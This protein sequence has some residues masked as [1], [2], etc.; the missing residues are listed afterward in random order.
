MPT[1]AQRLIHA[2]RSGN[3]ERLRLLIREHNGVM[4]C[5]AAGRTALHAAAEEGDR[6]AARILIEAGAEVN[7]R[8]KTGATPLH[9]AVSRG[10][11]CDLSDADLDRRGPC[12]RSKQH[13]TNPEVAEAMM[14]IIKER[15]PE[16]PADLKLE[17]KIPERFKG[18]MFAAVWEC[19]ARPAELYAGIKA[20]GVDID[21]LDPEFS[22][23]L[24]GDPRY[25]GIVEFLLEH[26]AD[27]NAIDL[28]GGT[29]LRGAVELGQ[30][31]VVTFLLERGAKV[32][33]PLSPHGFA[34]S[35][36]EIALES[37]RTK[38]ADLLLQYGAKLDLTSPGA[39]HEAAS[40][41]R[42]QVLSWLLDHDADI[43]IRNDYGQTPL[44]A[45]AGHAEA[46]NLL[47]ERGAD[48]QARNDKGEGL[49]HLCAG[50]TPCLP[51]LLSRGL[52]V[53]EPNV[54]GNTPLH[55]AA[56]TGEPT[57]IQMLIKAGADV[58]Q[59]NHAGN[60]SLHMVFD[61]VEC[62]PD[63][64]FPVFQMLLL[65]GADR[66][67]KNAEGNT[68]CDIARA[69]SYPEEYLLLLTPSGP[70]PDTFVWIG[71]DPYCAFQPG[72]PVTV[73]LDGVIWPSVNHYF[74]AQ[75]TT[76]F[77]LRELVRKSESVQEAYD[78]LR[79]AG[80]K[81]PMAWASRC[82]AIMKAALLEKFR[83][84]ESLRITL[85]ATGKAILVSDSNCDWYWVERPGVVFNE[86]GKMLM[87]IRAQ[88]Q[89]ESATC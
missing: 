67:I 85:L 74:Q 46:M 19:L 30:E 43:E 50:W 84:H 36:I 56:Q 16:L 23:Q 5:S 86:I 88:L 78:H 22:E 17:D 34:E 31:A 64:E 82:D 42:T 70:G 68:A 28:D 20:R 61:S 4:A 48:V 59:Q 51:A 41:G 65:A 71:A 37:S 14:A 79:E 75:K 8:M 81:T 29:V 9:L 54:D 55:L 80:V 18:V 12:G 52:S 13:P 25:L 66:A 53:N 89:A 60:T 2:I 39:M 63:I 33:L 7:A 26:G 76:S 47:L 44:L 69:C 32:E 10:G 38:I 3:H 62:R 72:A 40:N 83:Q 6:E 58:N 27:I 35:L 57:S 24:K 21:R 73:Q 49:L 11:G 87:S 15:N 77:E 45:A 1:H